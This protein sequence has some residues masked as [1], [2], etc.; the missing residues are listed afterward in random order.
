MKRILFLT[1]Y[2]RPDL[3]AGSFRNSPLVD[4][5]LRQTVGKNIEIDVFTTNPNRYAS[6][7]LGAKKIEEFGN[8][9]VER[10]AIPPH[11]SGI[12]DQALSFR[13]FFFETLRKTK[14]KDYDL[15]YASSSRFFTSYLAYRIAKR[16]RSPLF[17]DVRDIFSET[18]R[19]VSNNPVIKHIIVPFIAR[20][21]KKV[22][23]HATH[24]NLISEG[25][26][27]SFKDFP[28]NKF[29]FFTH[30][31]DPVFI[32]HKPGVQKETSDKRKKIL[33]AGNIGEGQ[34]L[35]KIVPGAA[36]LLRDQY[37][38][39]II[40]DGGALSKLKSEIKKQCLSNVTIRKPVD[41]NNLVEEYMNAD[42]LFIHLND[43]EI[44][45]KVLP[46]KIFELAVTGKPILAGVSGYSE[47]FL[48]DFVN[49]SYI[50]KPC[51]IDGLIESLKLIQNNEKQLNVDQN[52]KFISLFSR[53]N[54][55]QNIA[56]KI[57]ETI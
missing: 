36:K 48:R 46:S 55:N 22:Y 10:I 32:E 21:E 41:R 18:L 39:E 27:S 4:E 8:V 35:H 7:S 24:I 5:L 25:F 44:F 19:Y 52:Q 31:V 16:N 43:V 40:G 17:I 26:K 49:T 9:K 37:D 50:F 57:V 33:Y 30:G 42:I 23:N 28:D 53:K 47:Q 34:G 6:Y 29:S 56:A 2:F 54:I 13:T 45:R 20:L 3:C 51:D 38:F 12:I 1:F 11:K 14:N 15:V